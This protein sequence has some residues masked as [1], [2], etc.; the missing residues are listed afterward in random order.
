MEK[1]LEEKE[2]LLGEAEEQLGIEKLQLRLPNPEAQRDLELFVVVLNQLVVTGVQSVDIGADGRTLFEV[3]D[4]PVVVSY[5][6]LQAL[7]AY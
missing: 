2:R 5:K 7:L 1:L 4:E 6:V 3:V